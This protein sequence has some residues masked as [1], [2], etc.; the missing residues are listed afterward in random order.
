MTSHD[1]THQEQTYRVSMNPFIGQAK[2]QFYGI[3]AASH[4]AFL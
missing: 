4:D 3:V 1:R 2:V